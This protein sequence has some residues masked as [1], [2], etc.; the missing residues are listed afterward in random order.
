VPKENGKRRRKDGGQG[1]EQEE[2]GGE[3]KSEKRYYKTDFLRQNIKH[4]KT[5]FFF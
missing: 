3:G 4:K 2:E 1:K 5:L